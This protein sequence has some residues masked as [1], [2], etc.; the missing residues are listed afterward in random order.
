MNGWTSFAKASRLNVIPVMLIPVALGALG[1]YVWTGEFHPWLFLLTLAGAAAAHLFSNMINDLWDFKNGAD[2]EADHH[3]DAIS[4]N[5]GFLTQGI[6]SL[7][8]FE[9]VTWLLFVIAAASGVILGLLSGWWA[10]VLGALGGLIAYFYVAPPVQFGYRGKGYSEIAILLSFGILPVMGA[11]YVQTSHMDYR[12]LLLSLPIGLL[13]TLILFNHHFLHWQADRQAG[14][15]TLVVVW[16]EKRALRFSRL[17]LLLACLSMV[18]CVAA[19]ALPLYGLAALITVLPLYMVYGRLQEHNR[20]EAYLPLMGA[21][22]KA[23][24][25]SGGVLILSLLIQSLLQI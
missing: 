21:S 22:M 4:T 25:S 1:A 16:G 24:M 15:N 18:A 23:T 3:V 11:Y 10:F 19:G 5:S 2:G 12:A 9:A 8:K 7:R 17:L 13:T 6:W 14:K 20:S